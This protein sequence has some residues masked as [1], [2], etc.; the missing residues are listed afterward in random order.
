MERGK[1]EDSDQMVH[2]HERQLVNVKFW[3]SFTALHGIQTR[4][5]DENSV[6]PSVRS[7]VRLSVYHTRGL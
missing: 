7:S 1:H 2:I 6:R 3:V 5:S 4:S